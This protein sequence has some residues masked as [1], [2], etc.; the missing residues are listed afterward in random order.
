MEATNKKEY[1]LTIIKKTLNDLDFS[2]NPKG[3]YTPISYTLNTGGKRLRPL[4][5]LIACDMFAGDINDAL[6]PAISLEIFH[7]FTLLH[8]DI[9]DN[10]E[11]RRNKQTVH[12]KWNSS[13]AILSGDAMQILAY[14]LLSKT[15]K[16]KLPKALE[17]FSTTAMQVCEGQQY[18]MDF[19]KCSYVSQESYIKMITLKTAVL[20]ACSLKLGAIIACCNEKDAN[21]IYEF[22]INIGIAFQIQDD[23]LDVYGNSNVFGKKTGGDI[24]SN[25]KT[26]L[27]IT[28]LNLAKDNTKRELENWIKK[29]IFDNEEKIQAVT[30]IYNELNVKNYSNTKKEYYLT[31]AFE[32]L[33]KINIEEKNKELLII[34]SKE[35]M[36]RNF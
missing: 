17:L 30:N 8:D 10:A 12:K 13:I 22:G 6:Y 4:L 18:D 1:F 20:L 3:L 15:P 27:L 5:C 32:Y 24:L 9:M 34:I 31:K 36:K 33:D 26:L 16:D 14:Q 11:K 7:N 2:K 19:E 25:K 35:L 29:D 21:N 28:A 23:I